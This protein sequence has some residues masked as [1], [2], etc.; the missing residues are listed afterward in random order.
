M[1]YRGVSEEEKGSENTFEKIIKKFPNMGKEIFTHIQ[2]V[3]RVPSMI[4]KKNG[5]KYGD[6]LMK[7]MKNK[8]KE[9]S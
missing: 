3:Q 7:L 8:C 1:S 6:I 4:F 2:K 5:E 9:K